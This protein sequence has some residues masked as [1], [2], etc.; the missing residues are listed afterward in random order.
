MQTSRRELLDDFLAFV[1]ATGDTRKRDIAERLL[2][3]VLEKI[4]MLRGWTC[5]IDPDGWSFSTVALTRAYALPD[6]FGRVSGNN[7]VIRNL[8]SGQQIFPLDRN[9]AE[10]AYPDTET[11]LDAPGTPV[12][13]WIA[14]TTP[15][16]A[17][18]SSSGQALE[19]VSSSASDTTVRAYIEGLST[20]NLVVQNQVT[21]NGTTPVALGTFK[22]V[23][24][25]GKSYPAGTDPTT[26]LTTSVG[27]VTLRVTAGATLQTLAP[28]QSA[29][30]HQTIVLR[31]TPASVISIGLPIL[32]AIESYY[33][34]A[35]P[36]PPFWTNAVFDGLVHFWRVGDHDVSEDGAG[37]W[38]SLKELIEHDN[39]Q[40][41]QG[42]RFAKGFGL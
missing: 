20:G 5:F 30:D 39:A 4:W 42:R 16:Q 18:P 41:A 27:T 2:N 6:H 40:L 32:R 19:V 38:P 9:A 1:N 24:Q 11:S 10:E 37:M 31:P 7:R 3:R 34:D 36:L 17:Q 29:R 21:L 35:T 12:E 26:E 13:Y 25:F 15:V 8:T 23:L 33:L 14:G 28:W 22:R